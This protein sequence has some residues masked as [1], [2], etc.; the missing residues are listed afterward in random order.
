MCTVQKKR[1]RVEIEDLFA[2]E[3]H[4]PETTKAESLSSMAAPVASTST[5]NA[6]TSASIAAM[7]PTNLPK[8]KK[9]S[10]EVRL[11]RFD[12]I[13]KFVIPRLGRRPAVTAPLVRK[14]AW[15]HL[16]GLA[17]NEEQLS[18]VVD[19]LPGWKE[20]GHKFDA[21]FSEL[22]V[23]E[24]LIIFPLDSQYTHVSSCKADARNSRALFLPSKC[25]ETTQNTTSL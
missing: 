3:I 18:K 15:V 21:T 6:T 5:L 13:S 1:S 22:F 14:S 23:R 20:S 25:S 4:D 2:E 11:E 24:S 7:T 12:N 17:T 10:P 16:V 9:L 8:K 19:M